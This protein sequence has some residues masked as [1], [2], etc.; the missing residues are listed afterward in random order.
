MQRID[1]GTIKLLSR[2]GF[3][4]IFLSIAGSF[5]MASMSVSG[6]MQQEVWNDFFAKLFTAVMGIAVYYVALGL[7]SWVFVK[8]QK[9]NELSS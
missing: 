8:S 2:S 4:L 1:S 6:A 9:F 5:A 3:V 7:F